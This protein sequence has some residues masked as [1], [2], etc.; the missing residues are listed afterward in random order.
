M[1]KFS[2][3]STE[4]LET[5]DPR[6]IAVFNEVVKHFDCTILEGWRSEEDQNE[7]FRTGKSKLKYP[8]GKHNKQPSFAVDVAPY[9]VDWENLDRFR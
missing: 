7:A 8:E 2:A 6:L 1:P 9:P 5:C 4:R 3:R